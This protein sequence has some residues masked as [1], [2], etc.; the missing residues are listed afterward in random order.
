MVAMLFNYD[1]YFT[2][3]VY[4]DTWE[5]Y[6]VTNEELKEIDARESEDPFDE[7]EDGVPAMIL[8][9]KKC[10]FLS[11]DK[12]NKNLITHELFHIIVEYFHIESA[13]LE[14]DQFEEVVANFLENRLDYFIKIRNS[15]YR[16][17]LKLQ[18][19]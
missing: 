16:K 3:K 17:Y 13:H 15:I 8:P 4:G 1:R 19:E 18:G 12:V 11:D 5:A 14:V 7:G 2:F 6:L 9:S 10:L